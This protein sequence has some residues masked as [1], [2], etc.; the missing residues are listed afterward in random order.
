MLRCARK[1]AEAAAEN[2]EQ[3]GFLSRAD[4]E[5]EY[6]LL[7]DTAGGAVAYCGLDG[8]VTICAGDP[9]CLGRSIP[10]T[11]INTMLKAGWVSSTYNSSL[12]SGHSILAGVPV[13]IDE[14]T[15][16]YVVV[17]SSLQPL[18][19]F[20][21]RSFLFVELV[22]LVILGIAAGIIYT[23]FNRMLRP[24]REISSAAMSFG[25]GDFS[26]RIEVH[27]NNEVSE[28]GRVFNRMADDLNELEMS[29]RSFMGNLAHELRTPM[30][31]IGGYIDGILD[32]TIPP[33]QQ[34]KYLRIVSDEVKRLSRLAS[35]TLAVARMEETSDHAAL[36]PVNVREI[37]MNV[38]FSAERRITAK[39]LEVEGLDLPDIWML[40]NA[41]MMHQVLFNL[42][43]NAVKYTPEGG[44]ISFAV[45]T[46]AKRSRISIRNTGPGISKE[47]MPRL[48]DRFFKTDRSRGLD[49]SAPGSACISSRRWSPKWAA[50]SPFQVLRALTAN[51]PLS[52]P[53][54]PRPSTPAPKTRKKKR[55]KHR[56][57]P[58]FSA[59]S[60]R[61]ASGKRTG[62]SPMN[63][64]KPPIPPSRPSRKRAARPKQSMPYRPSCPT[65]RPDVRASKTAR[66]TPTLPPRLRR[67]TTAPSRPPAAR[68]RI[69]CCLSL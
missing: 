27:G 66:P 19:Q 29:R 57:G 67:R 2:Y 60:A 28:L 59:S 48:F 61:A 44:T 36:T 62:K 31:T 45:E 49:R 46:S 69:C 14:Q 37:L 63:G 17:L 7:A 39:S 30:T 16:G 26:A 53:Q 42:V 52:W 56:S 4:L 43:D 33:D 21:S 20:I 65:R 25:K 38:M 8:V 3:N 68:Y 58:I 5:A 11:A 12:L 22:S 24:L 15:A 35:S 40:C 47:D 64:Q 6:S 18:V 50:T 55:K 51:S 1:G 13:V 34:E 9:S 10:A 54:R 41:D 32:G 23:L